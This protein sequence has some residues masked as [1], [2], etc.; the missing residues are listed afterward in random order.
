[1]NQNLVKFKCGPQVTATS[2]FFPPLE[3]GAF[4]FDTE[5]LALYV[6]LTDRRVQVKDPLKLALTGGTITGD[7][8]IVDQYGSTSSFLN[9]STGAIQG[10]YL[11][12]VG[13][14]S[15]GEGETIPNSFAVIDENGRIRS[16][17]KEQVISELGVATVQSLGALAYKD[18]IAIGVNKSLPAS[19]QAGSETLVFDT[20]FISD[21]TAITPI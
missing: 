9:S 10:Q 3:P 18:S 4:V 5:S 21:I 7:V 11:E 20:E 19:V 15:I 14:I 8:R 16:L 12:T 13:N 6:D 1:M 2:P 17:T